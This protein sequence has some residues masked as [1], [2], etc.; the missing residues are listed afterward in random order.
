MST[1]DQRFF[2]KLWEVR[3]QFFGAKTSSAAP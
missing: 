3:A 2:P 1:I